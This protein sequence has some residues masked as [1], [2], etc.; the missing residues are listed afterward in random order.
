MV[1]K[2]TVLNGFTEGWLLHL[3]HRIELCFQESWPRK[4]TGRYIEF[5]MQTLDFEYCQMKRF[6]GLPV[7][8]RRSRSS[9]RIS[10]GRLPESD[11]YPRLADKRAYVA[12]VIRKSSKGIRRRVKIR[13]SM[14]QPCEPSSNNFGACRLRTAIEPR[15]NRV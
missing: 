8:G 14:F 1:F 2:R 7:N 4:L 13:T 3:H 6:L 9:M 5:E 10:S 12:A 15:A 11:G